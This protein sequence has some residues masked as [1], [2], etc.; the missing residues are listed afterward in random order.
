MRENLQIFIEYKIKAE[1]VQAYEQTMRKIIDLLPEFEAKN[2]Q[3]FVATDQPHLYVEM[4]EV[5]TVAHYHAL[6]KLRRSND[7]HLFKELDPLIDGGLQKLNCWAF[8]S[9]QREE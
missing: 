5:P 4:F 8:Q 6:K 1:A 3:W 9:C 7:H 2:I